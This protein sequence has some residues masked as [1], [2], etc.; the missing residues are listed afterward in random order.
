[1]DDGKTH[2]SK[3]PNVGATCRMQKDASLVQFV[4]DSAL[5][6]EDP[7]AGPM[8]GEVQTL[9]HCPDFNE[10]FTLKDGRTKGVPYPEIGFNCNPDYQLNEK[11]SLV[12]LSSEDPPNIGPPVDSLPHCPDFDERMTLN[13]GKTRGV[14][15]PAVGYN[16]K[17]DYQLAQKKD[18]PN[19]GPPHGS[20]PHCPDF[21][22]RFTLADGKTMGVPYPQVGYNCTSDYQLAQKK[23]PNWGAPHAS[24]EHCPDFDERFTL[25]DGKTKAIPYPQVNYNCSSDYQLAEKKKK[26]IASDLAGLPHCPDFDERFT[27]NDGKTIGIPYPREHYNCK[28]DYALS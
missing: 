7:R 17:A 12:Q 8:A 24:L 27:L 14:A 13:D 20:L 19:W 26:D 11:R 5:V 3:Y 23:D 21:D 28:A 16:C 4:D 22:E 2:V 6:E 15:Y 18:D 1:M 10:R 9:E 25:V